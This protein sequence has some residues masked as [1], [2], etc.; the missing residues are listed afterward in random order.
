MQRR[1]R[2]ARILQALTAM[3]SGQNIRIDDL[4][5]THKLSRRTIF[6][7]LKELKEIGVPY[8][9]NA[10][11]GGYSIGAGFFLPPTDLNREQA[12][13]L[14]LLTYKTRNHINAPFKKAILLAAMKIE[15]NLPTEIR[16]Y[17][18]SALRHIFIKAEPQAK[19][20]L[21]DEIFIQ[22]QEAIL[23]KRV[24]R[25][26]YY[27]PEQQ[28]SVIFDLGSYRLMYNDHTWYVVGKSSLH[29]GIGAF[30][31]N[32]IKELTMLGKCFIEDER[33][34]ISEYLG[35]AWSMVREGRLYDVKLKFVPEVAHDVA[36]VEWHSTQAV[37]FEEDGSAIV[38]FRVDGLN[39]ITWWILSYG[40]KVQVLA[41]RILRQK[42]IELAGK[43]IR[44]YQGR[45]LPA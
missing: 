43:I 4:V 26:C 1:S 24:V 11:T 22:L 25:I 12:M 6:R 7:D 3:Q 31:L 2:I 42:I 41:P 30:K 40:D 34:D 39:E 36:E 19:V 5:E 32:R 17:C 45:S 20:N 18:S 27:L 21:L 44:S 8:K 13:G 38:E 23:K 16:Q 33:F 35:R 15:N 29:K 37:R 28:N 14:L 10:E 9:Y